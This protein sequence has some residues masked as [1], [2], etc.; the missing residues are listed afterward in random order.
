MTSAPPDWAAI[1]AV[2][3]QALDQPAAQRAAFVAEA[4]LTE[5]ARAEVHS[6]LRHH[7]AATDQLGFLDAPG[8]TAAATPAAQIG[9]RFGAW[10]ITAPIGSGGMGE[11]FE[12]RRADGAYEGRAAIKLLRHGAGGNSADVLQRFAQERQALARL[13]H[14]HIDTL[15]DAGLSPQGAPY[16]VM[17]HVHGVPID[18]AAA[19]RTLE[20][21]VELFL[22]LADAV[23]HA[24]RK[25]LVHRDLKPG[26]VLVTAEGQVKLLDFGVAKALDTLEG[27]QPDTTLGSARP[28]TPN[29]ASPEQVRGEAVGTSTDIYSLGV[30][31]HQMLTG[32]RP[33]GRGATT[34]AEAVRSVLEDQ[35]TRP[36]GLGPDVVADPRWPATRKRLEGDLDNIVLKALEKTVERRYDSVDALARDLRAW[37]SGHPVSAH[38]PD[39]LY[40]ATKFVRRHKLPVAAAAVAVLALVGGLGAASWQA[41]QARIARDETQAR[42]AD[43]RGITRDLVF[44]FGDAVSYLPGGMKVKEDLLQ[45]VLRNLDRLARSTDRDPDLLAD[46][47]NTYAR[48]AELQGNDQSLSLGKPD[49]AR[50]NADKAIAL[51]SGLLPTRRADW[52]LA[53]W[54]ANAYLV[55]SKVFRGENKPTE[56]LK[57]LEAAAAVLAAVDLT[58]ADDLARATIMGQHGA[59]VIT[60]AQLL[61]QLA[62][63]KLAT[64]EASLRKFE[65]AEAVYR[66][67]AAQR[68]MLE[69]I[70]LTGR[71]EEPKSYAQVLTNLG[72]V[73]G[74][75]SRINLRLEQ[76]DQ[77]ATEAEAAL[78]LMQE[79]V[80]YDPPTSLWKDGL[81]TAAN[82][83]AATRLRRG[84]YALALTAAQLATATGTALARDDGPQSKWAL[85][86][87]QLGSPLGRALAGTGA[88]AQALTVFDETIAGFTRAR[89]L[90]TANDAAR[91]SASRNIAWMQVQRARSLAA[92]G[93]P[94]AGLQQA[95][96]ASDVLLQMSSAAGASRDLQLNSGEALALLAELDAPARARHIRA[97]LDKYLAA[98]A[99]Q[100]LAGVN[101]EA[102]RGLRQAAGALAPER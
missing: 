93:R 64:A 42:L 90:P 87:H 62:V 61:D 11:V 56:G 2:F 50:V 63:Q 8:A 60:E 15:F 69:R 40:L 6:L 100:A 59:V 7:A 45:D 102:L 72:V 18:D 71:P 12:A 55:R 77:A 101:A 80:A 52:R 79:A 74:G 98:D 1:K 82:H 5:A 58:E 37:R 25:L 70:D 51:A 28:Y 39:A 31:L 36:S 66:P 99:M 53:S 96:E 34:P 32:V 30:L 23:A 26:N 92:L 75:R 33:T 43:I 95:R 19:S 89:A 4:M 41:Q 48:L 16:F 35:P 46:V 78:A 49:A 21:R 57:E 81:A 76:L 97:A 38:A 73:V 94:E 65:E 84:E 67:L 14:P 20:A 86:L 3:E 9:E 10:E 44:R 91:A 17:E 22:Q 68:T 13:N 85:Q 47:A 83:M 24:H 54:A 29:Y 27:A 88:H